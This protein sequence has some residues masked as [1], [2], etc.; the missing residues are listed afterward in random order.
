[1]SSTVKFLIGLAAT[2]LMGWAWHGPAGN[3]ARLIDG[4]EKGARAAVAETELAGITV[5]MDRA[6]LAR[7]AN[8][9]G[10]ADDVQRE[11]LGSGLGVSD[12]VRDVDGIA[13]VRWSDEPPAGGLPLLAELLI[14]LVIAYLIGFGAGRLLWGRPKRESYL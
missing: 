3:G 12:Y 10:E 1:M 4:L 11:G 14:L 8:L 9:S 13:R 5:A 6:P 7:N 2:I